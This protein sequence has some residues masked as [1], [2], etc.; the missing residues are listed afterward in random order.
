MPIYKK[1]S[2]HVET[3]ESKDNYARRAPAS[4]FRAR[5][6]TDCRESFAVVAVPHVYFVLEY[7]EGFVFV[8]VCERKA[9][10]QRKIGAAWP[11]NFVQDTTALAVG[12]QEK[13]PV[14]G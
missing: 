2:F 10:E 9:Y 4:W 8:R 13:L 7:V 12:A 5:G 11:S 6:Q 14:E 3:K 1:E